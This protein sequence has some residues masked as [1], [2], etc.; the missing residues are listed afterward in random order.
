[1]GLRRFQPVRQAKQASHVYSSAHI[2]EQTNIKRLSSTVRSEFVQHGKA[3][4]IKQFL[5]CLGVAYWGICPR[6]W[7]CFKEQCVVFFIF[8]AQVNKVF[9]QSRSHFCG[10]LFS[11]LKQT[12]FPQPAAATHL[13]GTTSWRQTQNHVH[14]QRN[15]WL[16]GNKGQTL[17]F[18]THRYIFAFMSNKTNVTISRE[19]FMQQKNREER[20]EART[21]TTGYQFIRGSENRSWDQIR[22]KQLQ[23]RPPTSRGQR[24]FWE[25]AP[26]LVS[27]LCF[28]NLE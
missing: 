17:Q 4:H 15:A 13:T 25:A 6:C 10:F 14:A 2:Q 27:S 20:E 23:S 24:R 16:A 9:I 12:N 11:S 8:I 1:M 3:L 21:S 18:E 22:G 19:V 5:S 26:S 28:W 7:L